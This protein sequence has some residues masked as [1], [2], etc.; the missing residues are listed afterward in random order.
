[1]KCHMWTQPNMSE[2]RYRARLSNA[3]NFICI[4]HTHVSS[5]RVTQI[6]WDIELHRA[7]NCNFFSY[8]PFESIKRNGKIKRRRNR[9]KYIQSNR[10]QL[11]VKHLWSII[12]VMI[13]C[14]ND[15][16]FPCH[17]D[18]MKSERASERD[19]ERKFGTNLYGR[20]F[21]RR[22]THICI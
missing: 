8:W 14:F 2:D 21:A 12:F 3:T 5:F 22:K 1:M 16:N 19:S 6:Q 18:G 7:I 15:Q 13:K 17:F 9:C 10:H 11:K 4:W 20:H